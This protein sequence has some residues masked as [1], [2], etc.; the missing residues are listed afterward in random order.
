MT[1]VFLPGL[2][3]IAA[4]PPCWSS[5]RVDVAGLRDAGKVALAAGGCTFRECPSFFPPPPLLF[6][7]TPIQRSKECLTFLG[8]FQHFPPHGSENPEECARGM[9]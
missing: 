7:K 9:L 8:P 5:A 6:S 2:F 4:L 1:S 3:P